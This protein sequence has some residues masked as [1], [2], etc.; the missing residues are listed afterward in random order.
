MPLIQLKHP[1]MTIDAWK[2]RMHA[3]CEHGG[4]VAAVQCERGYFYGILLFEPVEAPD[5][6][7]VLTITDIV[8]VKLTGQ[9]NVRPL[10]LEWCDQ[11]ARELDC[12]RI[13][14]QLS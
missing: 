10:M 8:S 3:L 7:N 5:G 1:D 13:D 12:E 14:I 6:A 4:G 2:D 9:E 11:H